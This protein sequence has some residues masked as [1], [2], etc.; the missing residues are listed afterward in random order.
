MKKIC[1]LVALMFIFG[2]LAG[3]GEKPPETTEPVSDPGTSSSAGDAGAA[4]VI[5]DDFTVQCIDG[6]LFTLSEALKDH[7]MVLI[8]LFG[9][10][11]PPCEMEFP[12]MQ[13]AWQQN[14]DRIGVVALSVDPDDTDEILL[15]Y[16]E[17]LGITFPVGH[18]PGLGLR[19]R[20][21]TGY[22]TSI[23]VD[24][25]RRVA[26]VEMGAKI[27]SQEFLDWFDGYTGDRYDPAVCTYKVNCYGSEN[28]EDI[29]NVTVNFCTD[30]ACFPVTSNDKGV[31]IF[32]G[33]PAEYHVQ[34]AGV[35]DGWQAD[36]ETDWYTEPYS[37]TFYVAFSQTEQQ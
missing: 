15:E 7:E 11:C 34:I 27:S 8:N 2:S 33:P 36:G 5:V 29:A 1:I 10:F 21:V 16:A 22:P 23:L 4:S 31:A 25:N 28:Y 32:T 30:N 12:A 26:S 24:R 17:K 18:E 6:S 19:E 3:C 37:Q 14:A 13:E 35:P 20:F 9:T